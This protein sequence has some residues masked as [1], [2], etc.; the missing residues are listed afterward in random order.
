M[1]F[2]FQ[3]PSQGLPEYILKLDKNRAWQLFH[4][5]RVEMQSSLPHAVLLHF[6]TYQQD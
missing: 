4:L 5:V 6:L 1:K 3:L 2:W